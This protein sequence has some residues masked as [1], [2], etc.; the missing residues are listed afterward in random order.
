[1]LDAARDA[2]NRWLFTD[3]ADP[4][5]GQV[6]EPWNGVRFAAFSGSDHATHAVDVTDW[7]DE[8]V[9]SLA[10][11]H[12]YLEGLSDGTVG[13]DPGPFLRSIASMAGPHLGVEYASSFE[14]IDL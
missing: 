5:T 1:M 13:K 11:H 10:A 12:T 7:I 4:G 8:G 2:G 9:A 6:L 3:V 14:V